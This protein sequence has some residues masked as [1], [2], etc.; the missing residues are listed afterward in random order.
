MIKT[1]VIAF[2]VAGTVVAEQENQNLPVPVTTINPSY[3]LEARFEALWMQPFAN[4]LDYGAEAL[5]FNYGSSQPA[6]SP[7]WSIPQISTDFHFG[8]DVAIGSV[9]HGADASLLLHWQRF[10][11]SKDLA[12]RTVPSTN[13]I[14]SFFEIG[15]DASPYKQATGTTKFHWDAV[16]LDYGTFVR[17]GNL[18]HTRLF[19]GVGFARLNQDRFTRFVDLA[20]TV[21][22]TIDVPASFLGAGPQ[23]GV[24]FLYKIV[25]GFRF[26]GMTS[27]T[28]FV[29]TFE[30]STTFST[31]SNA[32]VALGDQN[33]NI[34]TTSVQNK[35][36]IV[37]GFEGKLGLAYGFS[38]CGHRTVKF[39]VGYR[40]Q[41]Y[42]NAIRSLDMGSEVALGSLGSVGSA[43]TGVYARTFDR[44]VSDFGLGGPYI[45]IEAGF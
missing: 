33:P 18:L 15:P 35:G 6:V 3:T 28:L 14:S 12:S 45:T 10:H 4:N 2:L 13:M 41:V 20:G 29:G 32:L 38:H 9:F 27:A 44:T 36:G 17:V 39:E 40:A 25:E 11:S 26:V 21:K 7:S 1:C 31:T 23:V 43:V 24:D 37:P 16:A 42:L 22:R 5:P 19:A 8:F 34:Q 30:N